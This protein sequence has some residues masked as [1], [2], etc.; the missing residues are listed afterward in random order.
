[1]LQRSMNLAFATCTNRLRYLIR[2]LSNQLI[3]NS[4][5]HTML[6]ATTTNSTHTTLAL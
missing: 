5:L 2:Q 6:I 3:S 1:M 4:T